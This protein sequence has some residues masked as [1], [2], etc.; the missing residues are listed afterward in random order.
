MGDL[1]KI[2]KCNFGCGYDIKEGWDNADVVERTKGI[3]LIFD[4]NKIPYPIEDN[5]YDYVL[6]EQILEHLF[7]PQKVLYELHRICKKNAIIRVGVPYYNNKSSYTQME[8]KIHFSDMSFI[9]LDKEM[10]EKVGIHEGWDNEKQ[11]FKII[12]LDLNPTGVG[13]LMPKKLREKLSLFIGGLINGVNVE[14]KVL[15]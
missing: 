5:T 8:H 10:W 4:F 7:E 2:K 14:L 12:Y 1:Q 13:K 9:T 3:N 11:Y 15:K 6:A